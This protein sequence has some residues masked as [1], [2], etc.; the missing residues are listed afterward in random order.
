MLTGGGLMR[1]N[2]S[3]CICAIFCIFLATFSAAEELDLNQRVLDAQKL[4]FSEK[5]EEA[6][7]V[8]SQGVSKSCTRESTFPFTA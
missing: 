7:A 1:I 6:E 2:I 4:I 8:I 5:Y 3:F